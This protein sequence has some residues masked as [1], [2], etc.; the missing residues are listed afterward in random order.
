[1]A[2]SLATLNTKGQAPLNLRC[3]V[4]LYD[5]NMTIGARFRQLRLHLKLSGD[6]IGS[7]CDVTKSMVSQ[8]ESDTSIPTVE[9]LLALRSKYKFSLDWV[10]TGEGTMTQDGLY[11]A[12]PRVAAI[13]STL[14]H[15]MEDGQEYLVERTQKEIDADLQFIAQATAHAKAKDC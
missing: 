5:S 2:S 7:I 10:L 1:M 8:W 14:L 6:D 15:A 12:E 11:I 9:R 13:A 3:L 4:G